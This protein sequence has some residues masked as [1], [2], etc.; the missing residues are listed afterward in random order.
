MAA[1]SVVSGG[2][3]MA[4]RRPSF[5]GQRLIVARSLLMVKSAATPRGSHGG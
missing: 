5:L 1:A 4:A 3:L 2:G